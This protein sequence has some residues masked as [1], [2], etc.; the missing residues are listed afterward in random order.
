MTSG[1]LTPGARGL[2]V[3]GAGCGE[4]DAVLALAD[5]LAWPVLADPR[6]GLRRPGGPVVAAADGILRST[7]FADA[8]RPDL[9]LR[10]GERWASKVVTAFV[11]GAPTVVVDPHGWADPERSAV[12]L[13]RA[14]PTEFC[15]TVTDALGDSGRGRP[16]GEAS[17]SQDWQSAERTARRVIAGALD[18][19][20]SEGGTGPTEPG[21]AARVVAAVP[22]G[23]TLVVSSSMP[24]RD[25]E[26]FG[27]PPE[28]TTSGARQSGCQRDRRRG[29]DRPR[30]RAG[31]RPDHRARG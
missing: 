1:G 11:G 27:A 25:V 21:L 17:W 31:Q 29:V 19:G 2:I 6:S 14:D 26:A 24:V 8:H 10:L 9:V 4:P 7:R 5:A 18:A 15:R 20:T 13:V 3:A 12:Q 22:D 16:D 23:S 28:R 30:R